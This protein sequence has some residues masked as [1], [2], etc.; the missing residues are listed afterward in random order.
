MRF[1]NLGDISALKEDI[2][3]AITI[4]DAIERFVQQ[5]SVVLERSGPAALTGLSQCWS[6][7]FKFPGTLRGRLSLM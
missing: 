1:E 7:T 5:R 3:E 6:A 2:F 4:G